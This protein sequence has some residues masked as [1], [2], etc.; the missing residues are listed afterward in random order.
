MGGQHVLCERLCVPCFVNGV[1]VGIETAFVGMQFGRAVDVGNE[2][3][4]HFVLH[5]ALSA[6]DVNGAGAALGFD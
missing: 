1:H 5:A 4:A 2:Q 3:R 6:L